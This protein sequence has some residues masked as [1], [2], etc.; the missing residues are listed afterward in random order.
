MCLPY[1]KPLIPAPPD[2][3]GLAF[4]LKSIARAY[5]EIPSR[6][7]GDGREKVA[8]VESVYRGRIGIR[9]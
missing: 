2:L 3:A 9:M 6:G 4:A 8:S 5:M 1:T 7:I